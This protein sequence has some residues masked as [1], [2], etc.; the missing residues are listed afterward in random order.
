MSGD[1]RRVFDTINGEEL[2]RLDG[3]DLD[4][5]CT[6]DDPEAVAAWWTAKRAM[7]AAEQEGGADG[8]EG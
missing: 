4:Q 6:L 5:L 3:F 8:R 1:G 7:W 2:V